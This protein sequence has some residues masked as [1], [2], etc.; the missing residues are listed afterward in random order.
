MPKFIFY[1]EEV[2]NLIKRITHW[3]ILYKYLFDEISVDKI[4][5][6]NL[7]IKQTNNIY[8]TWK[9]ESFNSE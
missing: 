1:I 9:N 6:Y 5:S 4:K 3:W 8:D 7:K 2:N